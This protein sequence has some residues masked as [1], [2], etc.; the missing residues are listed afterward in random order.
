MRGGRRLRVLMCHGDAVISSGVTPDLRYS[1]TLGNETFYSFLF[2]DISQ[3]GMPNFSDRISREEAEA[4]HS[5]VLDK[6]WAAWNDP[7]TE[8]TGE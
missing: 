2:E 8:K 7:D 3:R 4:I 5:Y 6:A 1:G